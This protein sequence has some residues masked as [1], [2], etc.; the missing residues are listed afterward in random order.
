MKRPDVIYVKLLCNQHESTLASELHDIL[1]G[2]HPTLYVETVKELKQ[3]DHVLD[4][5]CGLLGVDS[6]RFATRSLSRD[7]CLE[8]TGIDPVVITN[9]I[10]YQRL[11]KDHPEKAELETLVVSNPGLKFE[12]TTFEEFINRQYGVNPDYDTNYG[13]VENFLLNAIKL[14]PRVISF[15]GCANEEHSKL[16][17]PLS[18]KALKNYNGKI[19]P[20]KYDVTA[21]VEDMAEYLRENN[22]EVTDVK[23][24]GFVAVK[25]EFLESYKGI[26]NPGCYPQKYFEWLVDHGKLDD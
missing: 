21:Y 16:S 7:L 3:G 14:N 10:D 1:P 17:K 8:V 4:V 11:V 18:N 15:W 6:R 24:Y 23:I 19:I 9:P 20:G 22:W 13:F 2:L 26:M 12:K 25:K 5:G